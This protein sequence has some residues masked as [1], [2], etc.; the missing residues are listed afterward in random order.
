MSE[1]AT[2]LENGHYATEDVKVKSDRLQH[3]YSDLSE[4]LTIRNALLYHA[5]AFHTSVFQFMHNVID[6]KTAFEEKSIDQNVAEVELQIRNCKKLRETVVEE[7]STLKQKGGTLIELLQNMAEKAQIDDD[8][9]A[10][11][12]KQ[13]LVKASEEKQMLE[14]LWQKRMRDLSQGLGLRLFEKEALK[15]QS[16]HRV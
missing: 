2:M 11:H 3:E 13:L 15:V 10:N 9:S 16:S 1:A 5:L 12:V 8:T 14:T 7:F 4:A 6:W